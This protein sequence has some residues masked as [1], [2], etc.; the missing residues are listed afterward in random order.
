M[1]ALVNEFPRPRC[2]TSIPFQWG[3]QCFAKVT[4]KSQDTS[5]FQIGWT[6]RKSSSISPMASNFLEEIIVSLMVP[7]N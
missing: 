5:S 1:S 6:T 7:R 4:A 3:F 2:P